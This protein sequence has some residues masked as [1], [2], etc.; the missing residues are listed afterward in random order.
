MEGE[1]EFFRKRVFGG[2]NR[3]DVIKYISKIAEERNDALKDK[4]KAEQEKQSLLKERDDLIA[5]KQQIENDI[6]AI[7]TERNDAI[8]ARE[9][10]E[11]DAGNLAE[12]LRKVRDEISRPDESSSNDE[13][14]DTDDYEESDHYNEFNHHEVSDEDR[15]EA[16]DSE[17]NVGFD[18]PSPPPP[19][20]DPEPWTPTSSPPETENIEK[21]VAKVTIKRRIT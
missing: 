9:K 19:P 15:T 6:R 10:A 8:S 12:E 13:A 21:K 20:S 18:F 1:K 3:D 7:A 5:E 11:R 2:F 17:P 4:K 14:G 16:L